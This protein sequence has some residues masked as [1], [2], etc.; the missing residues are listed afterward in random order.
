MARKKLEKVGSIDMAKTRL[1]SI[2]SI[3][4]GIDLGN[5][6]TA[7]AYEEQ[8]ALTEAKVEVYNT[9]LS[10]V[11]DLYND[12]LAQEKVLKGWSTRVLKGVAFKYTD[13]SSEYEMA[14]GVRK[15]ERKRP[16]KKPKE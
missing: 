11:D 9:A 1:A 12:F 13:D 7:A 6:I 2:K 3:Q 8:I 4:A 15:S 14:G 5:G 10:K 16:S